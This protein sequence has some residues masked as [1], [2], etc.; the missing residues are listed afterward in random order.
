MNLTV[1]RRPLTLEAQNRS[2]DL[3]VKFVVCKVALRQVFLRVFR[4]SNVGFISPVP[5]CRRH[6][7]HVSYKRKK[8]RN[9]GNFQEPMLVQKFDTWEHL[10]EK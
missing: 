1:T 4:L 7:L 3:L 5:Q 9:L 6:H 2:Q 10:A 8:A